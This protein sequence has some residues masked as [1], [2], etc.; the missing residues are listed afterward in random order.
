MNFRLRKCESDSITSYFI[1]I[2]GLEENGRSDVGDKGHIENGI[3]RINELE[4]QI[5]SHI[6]DEIVQNPVKSMQKYKEIRRVFSS[7]LL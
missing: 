1:T 2:K 5:E 7:I 6:F 4:S 3:S